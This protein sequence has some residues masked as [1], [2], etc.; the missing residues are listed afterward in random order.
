MSG[1]R[2]TIV[3]EV[4]PRVDPSYVDPHEPAEEIIETFNEWADANGMYPI[5]FV[6]AEWG[7]H[8]TTP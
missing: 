3:I 7:H 4:P 6:G 8:L 2:L 5:E 1:N